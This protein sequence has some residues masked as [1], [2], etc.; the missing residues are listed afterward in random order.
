ME[1]EKTNKQ[2][3]KHKYNQT[4]YNKHKEELL[5]KLS[6]KSVCECGG[7]YTNGHKTRH[8]NSKKHKQYELTLVTSD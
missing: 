6:Q 8:M 5:N 7:K 1:Q 2:I 3:I 4:Y